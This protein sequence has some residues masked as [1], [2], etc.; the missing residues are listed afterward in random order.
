MAVALLFVG[1]VSVGAAAIL[2]RLANAHPLTTSWSR[3]WVGAVVLVAVALVRRRA[4]PRS[5]D[6]G[7]AV[8]AG[9]LLA[10]HF[11]LWIASLSATTVAAS[12]VLVCLQPVFVVV[13]ARLV[14]REPTS[15]RVALG[16]GIALVGAIAIALDDGGGGPVTSS[17]TG[18]ALALGGAVAIAVYVL[19]LRGQ[20]ADVLATS[21][22]ITA[23]AALVILP[24]AL[25]ADAPLTP[26]DARQGGWL[27]LLAIG[28]QV[29]GH[30]ALNA[31]LRRLP[32]SVVS[33]SILGEPVI[34]AALAALFLGERIG[35]QTFAG[36][37]ITLVGVLV[38]VRAQ[39]RPSAPSTTS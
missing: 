28:P 11:G 21:A 29:I 37:V 5:R 6:L 24:V 22:V 20:Q 30:T 12:V 36:G 17:S 14:L 2:I 34:A 3:L 39:K 19:V 35:A 31:A 16:I 38:L 7:R 8:V 23:T 15:A 26:Q 32:A 1:V 33:G 27:L 10:A 18:N 9:V 13:I 25:I 4:W